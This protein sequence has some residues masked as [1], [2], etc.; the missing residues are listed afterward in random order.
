MIIL[1][2]NFYLIILS[3]VFF[4]FFFFFFFEKNVDFT[5]VN[6]KITPTFKSQRNSVVKLSCE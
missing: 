2:A 6:L 1:E 3:I 5:S 4:F